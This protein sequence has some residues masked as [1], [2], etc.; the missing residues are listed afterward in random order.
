MKVHNPLHNRYIYFFFRSNLLDATLIHPESYELAEWLLTSQ[1]FSTKDIGTQNLRN[2]FLN[3]IDIKAV[4]KAM[5]DENIY[6]ESK[7]QEISLLLLLLLLYLSSNTLL[8]FFG[9][10]SEHND[11]DKGENNLDQVIE[12]LQMEL[13][14]DIRNSNPER[15]VC[16]VI[17]FIYLYMYVSFSKMMQKMRKKRFFFP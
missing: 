15:K 16:R 1:G 7:S 8:H 2:H 17:S 12:A 4:K 10:F 13:F 3:Q 14:A 9:S 5:V 6:S 11:I